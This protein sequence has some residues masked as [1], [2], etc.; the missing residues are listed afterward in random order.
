MGTGQPRLLSET[1]FKAVEDYDCGRVSGSRNA[2][3][4]TLCICCGGTDQQLRQET[5]NSHS[6]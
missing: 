5:S 6:P 4:V 3:Q 1:H 2:A